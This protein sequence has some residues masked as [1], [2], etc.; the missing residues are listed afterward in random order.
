M[1]KFTFLWALCALPF[2]SAGNLFSLPPNR[3]DSTFQSKLDAQKT[4]DIEKGKF[5]KLTISQSDYSTQRNFDLNSEQGHLGHFVK[6]KICN[7]R[8]WTY[9]YNTQGHC[10][11][12]LNKRVLYFKGRSPAAAALDVQDASHQFIGSMEGAFFRRVPAKFYF[13]D[14][15]GNYLGIA[16]MDKECSSYTL[17]DYKQNEKI[18]AIFRRNFVQDV[19]DNWEVEIID[20]EAIDARLLAAFAAF[21]VDTQSIFKVDN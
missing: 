15:K 16:Y 17:Y 20:P 11:F 21:A 3:D 12:M 9:F 8:G 5:E 19:T 10:Q 18:I 14:D 7:F 6:K 2:L 13:K 1:K 4:T